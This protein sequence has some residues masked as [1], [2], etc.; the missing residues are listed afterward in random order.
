[1]NES[2]SG[3]QQ[4]TEQQQ[5]KTGAHNY[6]NMKMNESRPDR[7]QT[8]Q[9]Q[10]Q[11]DKADSRFPGRCTQTRTEPELIHN[12]TLLSEKILE[13]LIVPFTNIV[14]A[15]NNFAE[16]HLVGS[17]AYGKVYKGELE[18]PV[19]RK[20][21]NDISKRIVAIKLILVG[22]DKHTIEGFVAE[23]HLL[24]TCKHPNIVSLLGFCHQGS[25]MILVYEYAIN[26]SLDAYL[27]NTDKYNCLSWKQRIKIC[28]DIAHGLKYLHTREEIHQ[29]I[30]HRDIK[31]G[32]ILLGKNWEAKISDFGF[33]KFYPNR[34]GA[35]TYH[36]NI[37]AG[38]KPYIDPVY[39]ATG[40]LKRGTDIYSFGVVLFEILSGKI[41]S[42]PIFTSENKK[43]LAPYAQRRYKDGTLLEMIDPKILEEVDE[44][45]STLHVGP[46][47]DSLNTFSKIAYDCLAETQDV[48]PTAKMI[49]KELKKALS[50]QENHKDKLEI[51]LED[52]SKATQNFNDGNLIGE[53]PVFKV[54]KGEVAHGCNTIAV[55]RLGT[56]HGDQRDYDFATELEILYKH[57]HENIVGLVGYCNE[58][59]EKIIVC[60]YAYNGSLDKHPDD[61]TVTWIKRLNICIDVARGLAFLHNGSPTKEMVIHNDIQSANIL[62]TDEWKAKITDFG[63]SIIPID[64]EIIYHQRAG[65]C[66]DPQHESTGFI[67]IESDIYAFGVLLFE[68]LSGRSIVTDKYKYDRQDL[69]AIKHIVFKH[70][71]RYVVPESLNAFRKIA[72]QCIDD[73]GYEIWEPKLPKDYKEL[74][75]MSKSPEIYSKKPKKELYYM[76]FTEGI[77]L[78]EDTVWF[79]FGA[80]GE[81]NKMIS[82][83]AFSYINDRSPDELQS[84]PESKA[85]LEVGMSI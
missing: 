64:G 25:L 79:S 83:S 9:Q 85:L 59:K 81:R 66:V 33:S 13:H 45:I 74:I 44:H 55:N 72:S 7:Q 28:I 47:Q 78:Q 42:D 32:N 54:Y 6:K 18:L 82:A 26:G 68:V 40:N 56:S 52:I 70:I 50:L 16:T 80:N 61:I 24:T 8:K 67:T 51:S 17:G 12:Q 21:K 46:N 27:G 2:R 1:M 38:T 84:T 3:R 31:S 49:V 5:I 62:L 71:E 53:G 30:I 37:I 43:G 29:R 69:T 41:A 15:T 73:E 60:E 23:I 22:K 20:N 76:F 57:K 58:E 36:T 77:L 65:G 34:T 48:R 4:Q 35:S 75:Q 10:I 11:A 19:E 14:S 39:A 63:L